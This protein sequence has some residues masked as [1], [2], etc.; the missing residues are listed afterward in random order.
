MVN[1]LGM[2]YSKSII[3]SI[4]KELFDH[5][6][7]L[8]YC[9][10][11][12]NEIKMNSLGMNYSKNIICS[13]FIENQKEIS[14]CDVHFR[15]SAIIVRRNRDDFFGMNSPQNISFSGLIEKI[16][17]C[18]ILCHTVHFRYCA[19]LWEEIDGELFGDELFQKHYFIN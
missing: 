11:L 5:I 6:L 3:S 16:S 13:C 18:A 12:S 10:I 8:R 1:C 14:Y 17:Y 15:Y 4:K 9:A 7:L 19:I 2:N